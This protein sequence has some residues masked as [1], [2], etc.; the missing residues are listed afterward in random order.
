MADEQL[1]K[2]AILLLSLPDEQ[3]ALLLAKLTPKQVETVSAEMA[4]L[5]QP[6]SDEQQ[7]VMHEFVAAGP[8]PFRELTSVDP[9][10]LLV[11]IQG[12]HPQT[13]A[14]I[15]SHVPR[16]YAA[17]IIQS[18]PAEIAWEVIRRLADLRP[19]SPEA[20]QEVERVLADRIANLPQQASRKT[21]GASSVME[22]LSTVDDTTERALLE[23]LAQADPALVEKI[24]WQLLAGEGPRKAA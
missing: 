8:L 15:L 13:I 5:G 19:S 11:F 17:R 10:D 9:E 14:L 4:R 24:R 22:I 21:G 7:A 16:A 2:A 23:S 20:V 12:E 18:L 6:G 3:A 1:R